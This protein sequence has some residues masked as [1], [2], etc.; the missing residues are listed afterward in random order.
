MLTGLRLAAGFL[1]LMTVGAAGCGGDDSADSSQ[2][3]GDTLSVY[4]SAP[5][6]GDSAQKA[7]SVAVGARLAL[8]DA[9]RRAGGF[10]VRLVELN[11]SDPDADP[12]LGSGWD[13]AAVSRNAEP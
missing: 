9:G 5:K 4:L 7:T 3:P 12:V 6:Q 1:A 11:S 2:A 8:R 13:P 10:R